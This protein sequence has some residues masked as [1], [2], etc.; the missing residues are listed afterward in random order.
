MTTADGELLGHLMY[1]SYLGTI[2]YD[3]ETLDQAI[4]E[5]SETLTGKYGKV[6][7]PA[8]LA[9][10]DGGTAVAAVIFVD[11]AKLGMPLLAFTMTHPK[12]QG[13]GLAQGL[14]TSC[15][16]NLQEQAFAECCLVVTKGN[17]P[18]EDI[19]K[20][21]GFSLTRGTGPGVSP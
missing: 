12:F 8:S 3:G 14:I 2:D 5:M 4:Q 21:L 15:L 16:R 7:F 18:A 20:K 13:R 19:Y 6:N 11:H 1:H 10:I 17:R 9:V